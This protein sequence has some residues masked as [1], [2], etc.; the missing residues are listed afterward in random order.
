ML[1]Y[2]LIDQDRRENQSY[3]VY[4]NLTN[5]FLF[6]ACSPVAYKSEATCNLELRTC[7]TFQYIYV[8]IY[9]I[10][11]SNDKYTA[12]TLHGCSRSAT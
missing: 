5:I 6:I 8:C 12:L 7:R 10:Q 2:Q 1:I 4:S 3:T 11:P 9:I